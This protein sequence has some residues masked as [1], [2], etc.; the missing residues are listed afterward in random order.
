MTVL[1]THPR[2]LPLGDLARRVTGP[3]YAG[4]DPR[5][6]EEVATFNLAV[7]HRPAVVVGATCARDVAAAVGWAR[8]HR[9][10][11]AVQA[12]GHGP[13]SPASG[14]VLVTT[15]RMDVVSVDPGRRT[16]RVGA[17]VRWADVLAATSAHGLAALSGSSSQV[18]V[19]GY[20]LG[21]GIGPLARQHGFA[22]DLV[23]SFE[24]VT[25]DGRIRTVDQHTER[26]LFWAVRGGKGNFGIVTALEF[27]LVP[28]RELYAGA[29]FFDGGSAADVLHSYRTWAPTLPERTTT[30]VALLRMPPLETL[31]APLRGRFVVALRIAHSGSA[32]EGAELLEPMLGAGEVVLSSVG[33]MPFTATDLIHSDPTDP[34][35]VWE[36]GMLL[37]DLSGETVDALLAVAGPARDV[38]LVMVE[39][40]QLGGA[41][42][43]QPAV[44]NAVA[45]REGAY[46][47]FVLGALVPGAADAVPAAGARV[48]EALGPWAPGTSLLNFLGDA[49]TPERVASA[50]TP[51]VHQRLLAVKQ[52]VDP[53]DLFRFGHA[54]RRPA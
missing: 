43:R 10:P 37:G 5:T 35:P 25:A 21:G 41:L 28:V 46:S 27:R 30:S 45:G 16:A 14:C 24:L 8:Q 1:D 22:A 19:V 34:M 12:T 29:V 40:R 44:P 31:P 9:L 50:W 20:T 11:V 4:D 15:K 39:L 32:A 52:A 6:P 13:V 36:R 42:S 48:L 3:V 23:E 53:D 54:L 2:T 7:T 26:E 17:G 18:G 51:E 38:P 47:A 49:T 33:E